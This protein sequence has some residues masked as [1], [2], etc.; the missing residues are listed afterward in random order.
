MPE[1][2]VLVPLHVARRAV[3]DCILGN[4][5]PSPRR[6]GDVTLHPHQQS[7]V[8]RI[9]AMTTARGGA[10]LCDD[11]GMG[12]TYI[13]LAV[14]AS[15]NPVLVIAPA[16]LNS[17]WREA[18]D[19]TGVA[20][21]IVSTESLGRSGPPSVRHSLVVVDEAHHFRNSCTRRYASLARVC[22]L[23]PV[24][25][26]TATPLHNSRRDLASLVA[27]FAGSRAYAMT[28]AE[29][30]SVIVRRSH[31]E[32]EL[33]HN[34][35]EVHHA[36]RRVL[37]RNEDV[38]DRIRAL[39]PAIPPAGGGTATTLVVHGLVRQ[40]VSSNAALHG[41][42][43][44]RIARSRSLLS[45]LD[46][47]RYPTAAELA[48]WVYTEDSV[49]LAFTELLDR[50]SIPLAHLASTLRAHVTALEKLTHHVARL[51][52]EPLAR[53]VR[54]IRAVHRGERIVAF[55]AYAE[56]AHAL[57][58]R[59]K[60]H[61]HV[62]LL[63]ARAAMIASG[64]V[65]RGEVLTQFSARDAADLARP[66]HQRIDLL[67]A[68][69]VLSEGV[70]LHGASVI[71]HLDLPWTD[72]R[73]KQREGRLARLGSRHAR[74]MA[75]AVNPPPR[76]D[77]V[78]RELEILATKSSLHSTLLGDWTSDSGADDRGGSSV[79]RAERV[80]A[81]LERWHHSAEAA[82]R[83]AVALRVARARTIGTIAIGAWIV[84]GAPVALAFNMTETERVSASDDPGEVARLLQSLDA[85]VDLYPA[86]WSEQWLAEILRAAREWYDHHLARKL[87][88]VSSGAVRPRS[89]SNTAATLSHVADSSASSA[90]FARRSHSA[91]L[92]GR[93][94][95][96]AHLRLPVAVEWSLESLSESAD[97]ASV[98]AMLEVV[99]RAQAA[100]H[101]DGKTGLHCV[102]LILG[103]AT[104]P[105]LA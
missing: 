73:V 45:A 29:L 82:H 41:A 103:T 102:A 30:A 69:D 48:A 18:L 31:D 55:T 75:Y 78:L 11:V 100:Q 61:G 85:A 70:D 65:T 5:D 99:E 47:G 95:R 26:L 12:K 72:A 20:A 58:R 80:I 63:T 66:E 21:T 94:R 28:E 52:D 59:L 37:I 1:A 19:T 77:Q 33:P 64:P 79:R 22:A 2:T 57:Y 101:D 17:M 36:S 32:G 15:C 27:L 88:G 46:A 49:Q 90:R 25:L 68:T 6:L 8:D 98:N 87:I 76:A 34:I 13:A 105:A 92:A 60:I 62:A 71:A 40:W 104:P 7:A 51:D 4:P 74:V 24:L 54:E 23:S 81:L 56:T 9:R 14:A 97:E 44:R 96:A 86:G 83:D 84:D 53:F 3:A 16:V 42:L 67:I 39:P 91:V 50:A 89:A 93:L 35:P 43:K 10:L 38:L